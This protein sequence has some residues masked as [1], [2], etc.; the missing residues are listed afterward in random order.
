VACSSNSGETIKRE[1]DSQPLKAEDVVEHSTDSKESPKRTFGNSGIFRDTIIG[2]YYLYFEQLENKEYLNLKSGTKNSQIPS[3]SFKDFVSQFGECQVIAFRNGST[4]SLCNIKR[5]DY[6]EKWTIDKFWEEHG[7]ILASFQN[8]EDYEEFLIDINDGSRYYLSSEFELSPSRNLIVGFIN[9]VEYPLYS[10]SF[11]LT[12][13]TDNKA[14]TLLNVDFGQ[15]VITETNWLDNERILL[16]AGLINP[17][18]WELKEVH[19]YV[20]RFEK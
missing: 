1:S 7:Q 5:G 4:D 13:L 18:K 14:L 2:D 6:F 3:S 9:P 20:L 12:E 16:K 8:W 15:R 19:P 11:M 10:N 17:D